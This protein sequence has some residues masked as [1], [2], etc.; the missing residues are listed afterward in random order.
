MTIP[1]TVIAFNLRLVGL[2][3]VALVFVN[4]ILPRRFR[5]RRASLLWSDNRVEQGE[6]FFFARF[7]L[8]CWRYYPCGSKAWTPFALLIRNRAD[9]G[10]NRVTCWK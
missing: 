9:V 6:I 8:F 3:M 5:W 4:V 7:R 1:S 10:N 2:V